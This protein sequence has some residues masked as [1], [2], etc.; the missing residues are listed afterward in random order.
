MIKSYKSLNTIFFIN[1]CKIFPLR[2]NNS[3][4]EFFHRQQTG[5]MITFR[6]NIRTAGLQKALHSVANERCM[7]RSYRECS[8]TKVGNVT[9][10]ATTNATKR[11]VRIQ[12][13]TIIEVIFIAIFFLLVKVSFFM[14]KFAPE[15]RLSGRKQAYGVV[16]CMSQQLTNM[17]QHAYLQ[18]EV[19]LS[20]CI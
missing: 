13:T 9:N 15:Y 16:I 1:S 4:K 19:K 18:T 5:V 2:I 10:C 6:R 20:I 11:I 17:T 12:C 7:E 3:C 14:E 8:K